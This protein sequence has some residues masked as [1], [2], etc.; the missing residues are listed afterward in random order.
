MAEKGEK[1]EKAEKVDGK[2]H[3]RKLDKNR[4]GEYGLGKVI[5]EGPFWKVRLGLHDKTMERVLIKIVDEKKST[6][7]QLAGLKR[8]ISLL[9]ILR[10]SSIAQL[11]EVIHESH[12]TFIVTEFV[13]GVNLYDAYVSG[14]THSVE[15]ARVL[16]RQLLEILHFFH[17]HSIYVGAVMLESFILTDT[18][19]LRLIDFTSCKVISSSFS[20]PKGRVISR[21]TPP[22]IV[23]HENFDG[24]LSDIWAAGVCLYSWVLNHFPFTSDETEKELGEVIC[25]G[26]LEFPADFSNPLRKLISKMLSTTPSDRPTVVEL[27]KHEWCVGDD[28]WKVDAAPLIDVSSQIS[29]P[30]DLAV[31]VIAGLGFEEDEVRLR[32]ESNTS[33]TLKLLYRSFLERKELDGI[34]NET[35]KNRKKSASVAEG[36]EKDVLSAGNSPLTPSSILSSS[37]L[38]PRNRTQF[39]A[40]DAGNRYKSTTDMLSGTRFS[41]IS[42]PPI[43]AS[44]SPPSSSGS[45]G[46]GARN[47]RG[48]VVSIYQADSSKDSIDLS[49]P[50]RKKRPVSIRERSSEIKDWITKEVEGGDGPLEEKLELESTPNPLQRSATTTVFQ[51]HDAARVHQVALHERKKHSTEAISPNALFERDVERDYLADESNLCL[52]ELDVQRDIIVSEG[53]KAV[54]LAEGMASNDEDEINE[55]VDLGKSPRGHPQSN[56]PVSPVEQP[57]VGRSKSKTHFWP[58]RSSKKD[59]KEKKEKKSGSRVEKKRDG[60]H[61]KESKGAEDAIEL[62]VEKDAE[63]AGEKKGK[64]RK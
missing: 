6:P 24:K 22:E 52:F 3:K 7:E 55:D 56:S 63:K 48:R 41:K 59:K 28:H 58:L 57:T 2:K 29:P 34:A 53:D 19:Q 14:T 25:K 17:S 21:Y 43:N 16:F 61:E 9:K 42:S 44:T 38:P 35:P 30:D 26:H 49:V 23:L 32:L 60:R 8:E 12:K 4:I 36:N 10:H 54:I 20:S 13:G 1:G 47:R 37:R 62:D 31:Q 11:L 64:H 18:G 45:A 46:V 50:G 51:T 15:K 33:D 5:F 39:L 27:M 40:L